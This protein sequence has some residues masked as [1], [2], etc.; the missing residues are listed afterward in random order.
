[1]AVGDDGAAPFGARASAETA[2]TKF[3]SCSGPTPVVKFFH[4]DWPVMYQ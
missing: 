4:G 3:R 2:M 1:M